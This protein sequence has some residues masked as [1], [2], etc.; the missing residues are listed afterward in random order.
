MEQPF[1]P[2]QQHSCDIIRERRGEKPEK[3]LCRQFTDLQ[4]RDDMSQANTSLYGHLGQGFQVHTLQFK[5]L[6]G[7]IIM[8]F[9]KNSLM[10]TEAELI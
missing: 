1:C 5:S 9:F 7:K 8:F 10:L 4:H 3:Q 6:V 2:A